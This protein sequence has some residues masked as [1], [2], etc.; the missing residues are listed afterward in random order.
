M[1]PVSQTYSANLSFFTKKLEGIKPGVY[2]IRA[3]TLDGSGRILYASEIYVG[4]KSKNDEVNNEIFQSEQSG[5]MQ[6]FKTVLKG[7]FGS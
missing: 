3:E 1:A 4:V 2:I 7:I 5:T 6:F